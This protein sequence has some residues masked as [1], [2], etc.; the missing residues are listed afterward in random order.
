MTKSAARS[1]V[2]GMESARKKRQCK[3]AQSLPMNT[4]VQ[5]DPVNLPVIASGPTLRIS[6]AAQVQIVKLYLEGRSFV[7]ISRQM[8]RDRRTVAKVCRSGDVQAMIQEQREKL[9]AEAD[10]W[11]ESIAF[12]VETELDGEMAF[13]LA[14]AFG[15][16]PVIPRPEKKTKRAK[17]HGWESMDP[18]QLAVAKVV[19][20]EAQRRAA[21]PPLENDEL[22]KLVREDKVQSERKSRLFA[23]RD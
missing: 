21:L 22:E 10:A 6:P 18:H 15:I 1:K 20:M 5:K 11:R 17:Q 9:I 7:E 8:H 2:R 23:N 4:N 13:R 16:I 12:V 14:Q 19:A 3:L